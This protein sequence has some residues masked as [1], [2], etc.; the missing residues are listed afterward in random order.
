M[1]DINLLD[2]KLSHI[3]SIKNMD[4]ITLKYAMCNIF[5]GATCKLYDDITDNDAL[6]FLKNP[7]FLEVVKGIFFILFTFVSLENPLGFIVFFM[8]NVFNMLGD[9]TCYLLPYEKSLPFSLAILFILIDYSK[10][11]TVQF[12]LD[13]VVDI[14]LMISFIC[15]NFIEPKITNEEVSVLKLYTRTMILLMVFV[16]MLFIHSKSLKYICLIYIG[17]FGVSV[18][19]QFYSLFMNTSNP[20]EIHKYITSLTGVKKE[21]K[22]KKG[23]KNKKD[24][25][26]KEENTKEKE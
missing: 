7:W 9:P 2:I 3:F 25:K 16:N 13:Y 8:I 20:N 18:A 6:H 22:N 19:V 26:D 23:K 24:K 21:K 4:S 12:N 11:E 14:S 15:V 1:F 10:M 17:Y 5:L